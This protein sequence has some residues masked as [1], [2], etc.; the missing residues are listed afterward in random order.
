M[1][2]IIAGPPVVALNTKTCLRV[3]PCDLFET[4]SEKCGEINPRRRQC[5]R[6]AG[7][8]SRY[9]PSLSPL[10]ERAY[11]DLMRYTHTKNV[12]LPPPVRQGVRVRT[13]TTTT[14]MGRRSVLVST[15]SRSA[16]QDQPPNKITRPA[17]FSTRFIT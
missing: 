11:F 13:T 7:R 4:H 3:R 10:C 6:R 9:L 2:Q 16:F 14:T 8:S 17:L 15:V 12:S 5:R 1:R